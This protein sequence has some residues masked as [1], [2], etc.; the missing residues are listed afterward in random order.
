MT[1]E[2]REQAKRLA[3]RLRAEEPRPT[4]LLSSDLP[5][6][7]ETATIIA[8]AVGLPVNP[9]PAW[10]EVN[11]GQ[12]SGLP[13]SE[14]RTRF[15]GLYWSSMAPDEPYPDGESPNGFHG[16]ISTAMNDLVDAP[17]VDPDAVVM[18]V[19]HGGP[20]GVVLARASGQPWRRTW[21]G[22]PI[23]CTSLT[24]VRVVDGAWSVLA[25]TDD[26]HLSTNR[27]RSN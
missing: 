14:V 18:V 17:N 26:T 9:N 4:V 10:R 5:R 11:A 8:P 27:V 22:I 13:E 3:L 1:V 23:P 16:R 7:L 2:G 6:A 24:H 12:L 20:I 19:T 15:P 21:P 25:V